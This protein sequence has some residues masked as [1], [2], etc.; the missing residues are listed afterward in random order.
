[1]KKELQELFTKDGQFSF[2]DH[3]DPYRVGEN[4]S[5]KYY[6]SLLFNE[7]GS[8]KEE[9]HKLVYDELMANPTA[10]P[11]NCDMMCYYHAE[12]HGMGTK[13]SYPAI[14]YWR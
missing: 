12:Q 14:Y 1:M 5:E 3:Y 4:K 11:F 8:A 6:H 10:Y 13:G 9:I 2:Q 7:N